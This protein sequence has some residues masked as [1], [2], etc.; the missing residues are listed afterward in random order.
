[1]EKVAHELQD[2]AVAIVWD[3]ISVQVPIDKISLF[4]S[5]IRSVVGE[6]VGG[7]HYLRECAFL[8]YCDARFTPL[9][10]TRELTKSSNV[11]I[12]HVE[13]H[14]SSWAICKRLHRFH[15][16]YDPGVVALVSGASVAY[17]P[18]LT[19]FSRCGWRIELFHPE[20]T[21]KDYIGY[22]DHN[23]SIE[24]LL[25]GGSGNVNL[26]TDFA[27]TVYVLVS[28][29]YS[30]DESFGF[31]SNITEQ[32]ESNI[33]YFNQKAAEAIIELKAFD[34]ERCSTIK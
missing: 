19:K 17:G 34:L 14:E 7:E 22:G 26:N 25:D 3:W 12:H 29:L 15:A 27:H 33:I 13:S 31:L 32:Y 2:K 30:S 6:H 5:N 18:V 20:N 8:V 24:R 11:D 23:W 21:P 4:I 1:M 10:V 16:D 9:A 28:E